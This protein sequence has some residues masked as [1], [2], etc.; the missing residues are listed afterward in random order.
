MQKK[1]VKYEVRYFID[2]NI[3]ARFATYVNKE[4][5]IGVAKFQSDQEDNRFY[6]VKKITEQVIF[7]VGKWG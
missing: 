3:S 1:K 6:F 5:A 7:S 4:E 2:N